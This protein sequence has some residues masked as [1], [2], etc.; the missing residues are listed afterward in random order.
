MVVLGL[1]GRRRGGGGAAGGGA[2]IS[3]TSTCGL[4]WEQQE[5]EENRSAGD[6]ENPDLEWRYTHTLTHTTLCSCSY[7]SVCECMWCRVPSDLTYEA[8]V[9]PW[10]QAY[11][12]QSERSCCAVRV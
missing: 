8:E 12:Q 9:L 2:T 3:S 10:Q 5:P 6:Q 11:L 1:Q 4:I 7:T